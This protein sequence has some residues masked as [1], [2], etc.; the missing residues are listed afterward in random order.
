MMMKRACGSSSVVTTPWVQ[1]EHGS[2]RGIGMAPVSAERHAVAALHLGHSVWHLLSIE[3][4][5]RET[6][7]LMNNGAMT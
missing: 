5:K 3:S 6:S 2:V 7:E 1:I 4:L